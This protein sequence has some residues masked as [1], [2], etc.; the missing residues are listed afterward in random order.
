MQITQCL[1]TSEGVNLRLTGPAGQTAVIEASEDFINWI[2]LKSIF[3][4]NGT[5]E[6]TPDLAPTNGHRFYRLRVQ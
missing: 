3:I 5:I 2:E 6:I 1:R 4:P